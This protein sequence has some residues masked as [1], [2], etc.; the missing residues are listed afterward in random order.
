M[1]H[2]LRRSDINMHTHLFREGYLKKG[3]SGGGHR[4]L[5]AVGG[6]GLMSIEG[7]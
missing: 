5:S 6:D 1:W 7:A 2:T 4:W 3:L